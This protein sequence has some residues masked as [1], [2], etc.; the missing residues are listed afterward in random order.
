MF[1]V[2]I[3]GTSLNGL[4]F[5]NARVIAK[6][7]NLVIFTGYSP[8][9]YCVPSLLSLPAWL[10]FMCRLRLSKE[11]IRKDVPSA[12]IR[13][14][15]LDL[16]SL[17]AVRTAAAEVNTYPEPI[18]VRPIATYVQYPINLFPDFDPQCSSPFHGTIQTHCRRLRDSDGDGPHWPLPPHK[19]DC[20]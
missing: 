8:E 2:L 9:R 10:N 11:A 6:Y 7:A 5:E 17:A 14:L 19:V 20:A 12:N 3:T 13:R 1:A 18:H 16:S 4:G 15:S